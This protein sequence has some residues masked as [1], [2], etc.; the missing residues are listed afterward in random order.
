MTLHG[1]LRI[2]AIVAWAIGFGAAMVSCYRGFKGM[3]YGLVLPLFFGGTL[4]FFAAVAM[5]TWLG[6]P[7]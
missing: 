6:V 3:R 7:I 5:A 4:V 2:I 1:L